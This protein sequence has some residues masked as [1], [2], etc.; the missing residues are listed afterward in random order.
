MTP[1]QETT[2]NSYKVKPLFFM[3]GSLLTMVVCLLPLI[4]A[5]AANCAPEIL[6]DQGGAYNP[7]RYIEATCILFAIVLG[8]GAA[9]SFVLTF[10]K[11]GQA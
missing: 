11:G 2:N 3:L 6:L 9:V 7:S 5:V 1:Q 10:G 4:S 8:G